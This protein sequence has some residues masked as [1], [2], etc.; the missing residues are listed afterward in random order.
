[1]K[2][3]DYDVVIKS[4]DE[5]QVGCQRV[6]RG[7]LMELLKELDKPTEPD[8]FRIWSPG[9][10]H[11]GL[12]LVLFGN[13]VTLQAVDKNGDPVYFGNLIFFYPKTR[14]VELTGGVNT[15][16]GFALDDAGSLKVR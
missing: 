9:C 1:M 13:V 4:K 8:Y 6:T 12:R 14:K 10:G 7:E 11:E 16:L 5:L 15:D 2:I 3:G